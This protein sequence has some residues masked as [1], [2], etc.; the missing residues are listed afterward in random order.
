MQNYKFYIKKYELKQNF[1]NIIWE[2]ADKQNNN[3]LYKFMI[4]VKYSQ[5]YCTVK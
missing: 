5:T 2:S 4:K 3:N 1:E